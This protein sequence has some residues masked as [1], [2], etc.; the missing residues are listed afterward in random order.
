[1]KHLRTIARIVAECA[2][3]AGVFTLL[4]YLLN[5]AATTADLRKGFIE[6][7]IF[8]LAI[9]TPAIY[10]LDRIYPLVCQRGPAV[11]WT[12]F[13]ATLVAICVVACVPAS[14][15]VVW[16][17]LERAPFATIFLASLKICIPFALLVGIVQTIFETQRDRLQETQLQLRT[18]ER[19]HERAL[20]LAAEARLAS[21]EAHLHPHFLFNTLNSISSL[22]PTQPERAERLV[23]RMAALLRFAL[24]ASNGGLVSVQDELKLVTD[25]LE[26]EQARLG[27]RLQ[28]SLDVGSGLED[29]RVPPFSIQTLVENSVKHAIAPNRQGGKVHI[30]AEP[31]T[32]L[33]QIKVA[34]TG[35]GFTMETIPSS[36]GLDNLR[37]R[38]AVLFGDSASLRLNR[39]HGGTVV[40]LIIPVT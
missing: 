35:P 10:V 37:E 20:K 40:S 4:L 8:A 11:R 14:F 7:F 12:V 30:S 24:D 17:G 9:G 34:D 29:A 33:L 31:A 28:Y 26:I 22:I 36:H 39:V 5:S 2:G 3:I 16:L 21:L 32:G 15:A 25:Y 23:E 38:L 27:P 6:A 13:A 1:M 19:E 18:K